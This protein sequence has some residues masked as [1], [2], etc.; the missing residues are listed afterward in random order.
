MTR[1][2]RL[3]SVGILSVFF[4]LIG[5]TACD[6]DDDTGKKSS[7]QPDTRADITVYFDVSK[8]KVTQG[9]IDATDVQNSSVIKEFSTLNVY[10]ENLKEGVTVDYWKINGK[11][12]DKTGTYYQ[13]WAI[14]RDECQLVEG[15][16]VYGI[17]V[18][19][20]DLIR[21]EVT[22]DE[23]AE[24]FKDVMSKE[25]IA[26]GATVEE[27]NAS[28]IYF[29]INET[30]LAADFDAGKHTYICGYKLNGTE[31]DLR[32]SK[33]KRYV[34]VDLT[35]SKDGKIDFSFLTRESNTTKVI[36]DSTVF[37]VKKDFYAKRGESGSVESDKTLIYEGEIVNLALVSGEKI[38]SE[39]IYVNG[40]SLE[41]FKRIPFFFVDGKM[42]VYYSASNFIEPNS[43]GNF[44]IEYKN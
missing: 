13:E 24:C 27:K 16:Y 15:K 32:S 18:V 11:R 12:I 21:A 23:Y 31:Y 10:A 6:F 37:T 30:K 9:N 36:F 1:N 25:R 39:K 2:I 42:K 35:Q 22:Y 33:I 38:A 28:S 4:L 44:V 26:S 3:M 19:L 41:K 17:E 14:T 8:I 40:I 7:G 20:R 43:D 34:S 29:N 5:L